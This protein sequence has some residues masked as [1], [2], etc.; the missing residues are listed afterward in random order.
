MSFD[1]DLDC[2][3]YSDGTYTANG[4]VLKEKCFP[5]PTSWTLRSHF[6]GLPQHL[7][8]TVKRDGVTLLD[9]VPMLAY[10]IERP[11]NPHCGPQCNVASL[12]LNFDGR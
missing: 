6:S 12:S 1:Q 8:V 5:I 9:A 2:T 10:H 3:S 7:E 11:D 4:P